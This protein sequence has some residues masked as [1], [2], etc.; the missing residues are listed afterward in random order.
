EPFAMRAARDPRCGFLA[1][2]ARS[3]SQAHHGKPIRSL[4]LSLISR[5]DRPQTGVVGS[6]CLQWLH[7]GPGKV[8]YSLPRR[9]GLGTQSLGPSPNEVG[10][11]P[12][13]R[14]TC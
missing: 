10:Y 7:G 13:K 11:S 8:S 6:V 14:Q 1:T 5:N 2:Q 3:A 4:L 9:P 12:L